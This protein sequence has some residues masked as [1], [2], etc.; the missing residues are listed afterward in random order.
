[1]KTFYAVII[2]MLGML[3]GA[4]GQSPGVVDDPF[5]DLA[6]V[7]V[8]ENKAFL[9]NFQYDYL[10]ENDSLIVASTGTSR[11]DTPTR[12]H[13]IIGQ[14]TPWQNTDEL[15]FFSDV[16]IFDTVGTQKAPN[17]FFGV[18]SFHKE[19]VTGFSASSKGYAGK[20]QLSWEGYPDAG[21][22][23]ILR[24]AQ[25]A[26]LPKHA[27]AK[28]HVK[29]GLITTFSD[30]DVAKDQTYDYYIF[31]YRLSSV[32]NGDD[33]K[34]AGF[35]T[36]VTKTTGSSDNVE[37]RAYQR[38]DV[39][40]FYWKY[41]NSIMETTDFESVNDRVSGNGALIYNR[42]VAIADYNRANA[43][44]Q[45]D[46]VDLSLNPRAVS[47][48]DGVYV[49]VPA[50]SSYAP[51]TL[52]FWLYTGELGH[53][54]VSV[55]HND[56][57][58]LFINIEKD[59]LHYHFGGNSR[60]LHHAFKSNEW[61]YFG[62]S[63]DGSETTIVINGERI[64][65]VPTYLAQPST[66]GVQTIHPQYPVSGNM[67]LGFVRSWNI[68]R[69]VGQ[70]D[71]DKYDVYLR[72][73]VANLKNQW[74]I[75]RNATVIS[76]LTGRGT[77]YIQKAN[78]QGS[79][80][81]PLIVKESYV[82]DRTNIT[83]LFKYRTGESPNTRYNLN[84]Y[85]RGSG[86]SVFS[87]E[88]APD[89]PHGD[90]ANVLE[91]AYLPNEHLGE[92]ALSY[93]TGSTFPTSYQVYRKNEEGMVGLGSVTPN[94]LDASGIYDSAQH[95]DYFSEVNVLAT[96]NASFAL[97]LKIDQ[98]IID[99]DQ[100]LVDLGAMQLI[101]NRD[102]QLEWVVGNDTIFL[103]TIVDPVWKELLFSHRLTTTGKLEISAYLDGASVAK[104]E[105][106]PSSYHLDQFSIHGNKTR[107][108]E[109]GY[110]AFKGDSTSLRQ[111]IEL[112][113]TVPNVVD[114]WQLFYHQHVEEEG[115]AA[116]LFKTSYFK[117]RPF[118]LDDFVDREV[119]RGASSVNSFPDFQLFNDQL[120][121]LLTFTDTF[122]E[123]SS[124]SLQEGAS[125]TYEVRPVYEGTFG[126]Q[127]FHATKNVTI[128]A[129]GL[130]ATFDP[131]Q[132]HTLLNWDMNVLTA[133]GYDSVSVYRNDEFLAHLYK[134]G[135]F[136]DSLMVMGQS[137]IYTL[138]LI[139]NGRVHLVDT[140]IQPIPADGSVAGYLISTNGHFIVPHTN[141]ELTA[142]S[143]A[144]DYDL[145]TNQHGFFAR[146]G[147]S[148]GL[149]STFVREHERNGSIVL[150]KANPEA[151]RTFIELQK[152]DPQRRVSNLIKHEEITYQKV[153]EADFLT[154]DIP[155]EN[156]P[157]DTSYYLNVYV[158]DQ[159]VDVLI[160]T[161]TYSDSVTVGGKNQYSFK[162][163]Y[164]SEDGKVIFDL[165]DYPDS[166]T[167]V[168]NFT[169]TNLSVA[170]SNPY[171]KPM[172][173]WEYPPSKRISRF[174]VYR[175]TP[176]GTKESVTTTSVDMEATSYQ[177]MDD[178]GVPG[179]AY[180]YEVVPFN[181]EEVRDL[182][183]ISASAFTYPDWKVKAP[184]SFS[185]TA[186]SQS[187]LLQCPVDSL[188]YRP[189][190]GFMVKNG[191]KVIGVIPKE[192]YQS[193]DA[194]T[195]TLEYR[196][197]YAFSLV[198]QLQPEVSLY[199]RKAAT[200]VTEYLA[201]SSQHKDYTYAFSGGLTKVWSGLDPDATEKMQA[202]NVSWGK[203]MVSPH[204]YKAYVSYGSNVAGAEP[205]AILDGSA[206]N[207]A[208]D[209][210]KL[211]QNL[212]DHINVTVV[213][214]NESETVSQEVGHIK[215]TFKANAGDN[216]GLPTHFTGSTTS[217]GRIALSWGYPTNAFP[218][219][220]IY[221]DGQRITPAEGLPTYV[222]SYIDEDPSLKPGRYYSYQ[223][224]AVY[225]SPK[226]G[227]S[228]RTPYYNSVGRVKSR[229]HLF[230]QVTD[231]AG[232]PIPY[233]SIQAGNQWV[234]ADSLGYYSIKDA[235]DFAYNQQLTIKAVNAFFGRTE[236]VEVSKTIIP[237][238]NGSYRQDFRFD[239][240]RKR[241]DRNLWLAKAIHPSY[242][243]D[244]FRHELML[245]WAASSHRY[246]YFTVYKWEKEVA[247][248]NA[249]APLTFVDEEV[250]PG[251]TYHY[252][253][254]AV[255]LDE[256]GKEQAEALEDIET[257]LAD[258]PPLDPVRF[259]EATVL[260]DEGRIRF[261]WVH[262]YGNVDGYLIER[263]G[264]PLATIDTLGF[265]DETGVP[266]E[267]YTY[268]VKPYINKMGTSFFSK[269][270]YQLDVEYPGIAIVT[271]F[272]AT[273][274][275]Q[276]YE[277]DLTWEYP[278]N[279]DNILGV[280]I[281]REEDIIAELDQTATSYTDDVGY[282]NTQTVYKI[283]TIGKDP[284][285]DEI[286]YLSKP[287]LDTVWYP[288]IKH[289]DALLL[290]RASK[291]DTLVVA[292]EY[293]GLGIDAFEL[294][295]KD[296]DKNK[297]WPVIE[298]PAEEGKTSY[299][300]NIA[301]QPTGT[302]LE[303]SVQGRRT[304]NDAVYRSEKATKQE[305]FP[306]LPDTQLANQ[307]VNDPY[308]TLTWEYP[309]FNINK[310]RM[311]VDGV[312]TYD[313][314]PGDRNFIYPLKIEDIQA[315]STNS[316][317]T[318]E[319]T[320]DWKVIE[321]I[322]NPGVGQSPNYKITFYERRFK[323]LSG[324]NVT[325]NFELF[326]EIVRG[327]EIILERLD[328]RQLTQRV[329]TDERSFRRV[330]A[331][332]TYCNDA[333]T[334]CAAE[335][336][337][338]VVIGREGDFEISSFSYDYSIG[339]SAADN[340]A[341][342]EVRI[343]WVSPL[344]P[345]LEE[346]KIVRSYFD[347]TGIHSDTLMSLPYLETKE[348]YQV[349]DYIAIEGVTYI[350]EVIGHYSNSPAMMKILPDLGSVRGKAS[351]LAF[352][353]SKEGG[354]PVSGIPFALKGETLGE[355]VYVKDTS[356]EQGNIELVGLPQRTAD[357]ER[358]DY[359]FSSLL[360]SD[361]FDG[362]SSVDFTFGN[363]SQEKV[364][365]P[366]L[367]NRTH[368]ISGRVKYANCSACG[369][370][371]ISVRLESFK[372]VALTIPA[373]A[374]Q[375]PVQTNG[376]GAFSFSVPPKGLFYYKL[377]V[378]WDRNGEYG[379]KHD[380][381]DLETTFASYDFVDGAYQHDFIDSTSF[382]LNVSITDGCAESLG[383]YEFKL[384]VRDT[385]GERYDSVFHTDING[386]L[387]VHVPPYD[388][389]VELIGT[390]QPDATSN[391]IID[392]FRSRKL[393][394]NYEE[395]FQRELKQ[396]ETEG[397]NY[398]AVENTELIFSAFSNLIFLREPF[399]TTHDFDG[400][401]GVG[402]L[403][404]DGDQGEV[405]EVRFSILDNGCA[406]KDG[407]I[408]VKNP[409]ASILYQVSNGFDVN[410]TFEELSGG[411]MEALIFEEEQNRQFV[412]RFT[413]VHPNMVAPYK[414][415]VEVF[416][417][418]N[419]GSIVTRKSFEY[420]V[421][422]TKPIEG[423]DV[424]VNP[425]V[426]GDIDDEV[427]VPL[428]VL[429]DPPGDQS[430]SYL[431]EGTEFTY[432]LNTT[433]AFDFNLSLT[434]TA[435]LET[436]LIA[437]SKTK[438]AIDTRR[439]NVSKQTVG[440]KTKT[441]ISTSATS[442][443]S[444]NLKGN[445]DGRDADV[446]VG[447]GLAYKYG[448]MDRLSWDEATCRP[449]KSETYEVAAD[450]I[451]TTWV[452]TRSMIDQTIKY[453]DSLIHADAKEIDL[454]FNDI[455]QADQERLAELP[456]LDVKAFLQSSRDEWDRIRKHVDFRANPICLMREEF[457]T[458]VGTSDFS[459]SETARNA[460]ARTV[461]NNLKDLTKVAG[462]LQA[463]GYTNHEEI[464]RIQ[465][466]L[467][468]YLQTVSDFL[469]AIEDIDADICSSDL[470]QAVDPLR[471]AGY[472]FTDDLYNQYG[473]AYGD[474]MKVLMTLNY[475]K[476][477]GQMNAIASLGAE[478]QDLDDPTNQAV[479][480]TSILAG[481]FAAKNT[482]SYK[483]AIVQSA[484]AKA[485]IK[486]AEEGD[487][488]ARGIIREA[489]KTVDGLVGMSV[490]DFLRLADRK[491]V[492]KHM[493]KF[494]K[495]SGGLTKIL[496]RL[497]SS[498]TI[499]AVSTFKNG[500]TASLKRLLSTG[501]S[502][503]SAAANKAK[504][505]VKTLFRRINPASIA[506]IGVDVALSFGHIAMAS[507]TYRYARG[508][509]KD[510]LNVLIGWGDNS[511]ETIFG[512]PPVENYTISGG[513]KLE[514]EL[515]YIEGDQTES[516]QHW[517]STLSTDIILG[518]GFEGSL[519]SG[520]PG[521]TD[522]NVG[523]GSFT[524]T[525]NIFDR[526]AQTLGNSEVRKA[527][528]K[529]GYVLHDD[530]E[531]DHITTYVMNNVQIDN[532]NKV[533]PVFHLVG[534]R[535][536]DPY[537]EGTIS[538][539]LPTIRF[540]DEDGNQY[541]TIQTNLDPNITTKIPIQ[542]GS[543]NKFQ[544]GRSLAVT[545]V[546]NSN[547][548]GAEILL[549]NS[550]LF[551]G[552]SNNYFVPEGEDYTYGYVTISPKTG[553]YDYEDLALVI[554]PLGVKDDF[555]SDGAD[556][557]DTLDF[558]LYYR[559][560]VSD[561]RI[562]ER[563]GEWII[564][565]PT[566]NDQNTNHVFF[567][568]G[569]DPEGAFSDL[570]SIEMQ[571]KNVNE[572]ANQWKE[573][574]GSHGS[575]ILSVDTLRTFYQ[576]YIRT[577]VDPTYLF[578]LDLD[579]MPELID[580]RY[581]I[582]ALAHSGNG[583]YSVSN[584]YEGRVDRTIPALVGLPQPS[585]GVFSLGDQISA[586]FDEN[587]DKQHFISH[588]R[589]DVF[590][591]NGQE[592]VL[593]KLNREE[594][595]FNV[596]SS[597]NAI[598]IT[599][600]NSLV[601]AFDGRFATVVLKGIQDLSG[602]GVAEDSVTW[603]FQLDHYRQNPSPVELI[604]SNGWVFNSL[605]NI[606]NEAEDTISFTISGY[607]VYE[608]YSSLRQVVLQVQR[609]GA[610]KWQ[611]VASV[612][613]QDLKDAFDSLGSPNLI[614]EYKMEWA[615]NDSAFMVPDGQYEV[616]ALAYGAQE[617]FSE[618]QTISGTIDRIVPQV[619]G[620]PQPSD[621]ILRDG[622]VVS[623]DFTEAI[624]SENQRIGVEVFTDAASIDTDD[625]EVQ[626][627]S[628]GM[629]VVFDDAFM[630][631]LPPSDTVKVSVTGVE[632]LHGNPA[633]STGVAFKVDYHGV[634]ASSVSI[635][636]NSNWLVNWYSEPELQVVISDY[637][638]AADQLLDSIVLEYRP[639]QSGQEGWNVIETLSKADLV[640]R[641]L[642]KQQP[643]ELP[644][645]TLSWYHYS[646]P[647]GQYE[648][649]AVA[650][651]GQGYTISNYY[652]GRMDR[653]APRIVGAPGPVTKI[654]SFEEVA[655]IS[656]SETINYSE[657]GA[658]V[659]LDSTTITNSDG[660]T[661]GYDDY[662]ITSSGSGIELLIENSY[663]IEHTGDTLSVSIQGIH[664][665]Y[666]NPLFETLDWAFRLEA[667][668][669]RPSAVSLTYPN[670][671]VVNEA[672]KSEKVQFVIE[673]YDLFEY[674]SYLDEVF[675]EY[676]LATSGENAWKVA[677]SLTRARLVSN[678]ERYVQNLGE[679]AIIEPVDT[680]YF[681]PAG[682]SVDGNYEFRARISGKNKYSHSGT[683]SGIIDRQ[684][685]MALAYHPQDGFFSRG[686]ELSV[687]F[688]EA[689]DV[690][691]STPVLNI[692]GHEEK[693][694]FD[695]VLSGSKAVLVPKQPFK[696]DLLSLD[697]HTLSV[698]LKGIHDLV[699]N[700]ASIS[701]KWDVTVNSFRV[702]PSPVTLA[703]PSTFVVTQVTDSVPLTINQFDLSN[704]A[705]GLDVIELEYRL[706]GSDHWI[707]ITSF[708]KDTLTALNQGNSGTLEATYDWIVGDAYAEGAYQ[709]R[710]VSYSGSQYVVSNEVSGTVDRLPPMLTSFEPADG[711][712]S[713]GD[714]IQ[715]DFNE[716]LRTDQR[717]TISYT[718]KATGDPLPNS[719]FTISN[720]SGGVTLLPTQSMVDYDGEEIEVV[721][722][723]I[724]DRVGNQSADV[725]RSFKVDYFNKPPSSVD[726]IGEDGFI[727]NSGHSGE[728]Q[729]LARGY[730]LYEFT[731][732]LDRIALEYR[733][734]SGDNAWYEY[735][736][737]N[738][739]E[740]LTDQQARDVNAEP[741]TSFS[742]KTSGLA[743]GTYELRL[744]AHAGAQYLVSGQTLS[745]VIDKEAPV[746]VFEPQDGFLSR[747]DQLGF[748]SNEAIDVSTT[749]DLK[750]EHVIEGGTN[751]DLT[752]L[753]TNVQ[754]KD[755]VALLVQAYESLEPY[756]G[757]VLQLRLNSSVKDVNGN[758]YEGTMTLPF[759]LDF[760][761]PSI[762]SYDVVSPAG[763]V[764]LNSTSDQVID[765]VIQ[766]YDL[767]GFV[768][769]DRVQLAVQHP[770]RPTT[771]E[772]ADEK[773]GS[774]LNT[775][776]EIVGALNQDVLT[777]V[778]DAHY[779][780]GTYLLQFRSYGVED[781]FNV[782]HTAT[783]IVDRTSP[784]LT[785][786][787]PQDGILSLGDALEYRFNESLST[788]PLATFEVMDED[789]ND[790]SADFTRVQSSGTVTI[791][792]TVDLLDHH[793]KLLTI[794]L[795]DVADVAGNPFR[796]D[797]TRPF[798]VDYFTLPPSPVV[799]K[800]VDNLVI[801]SFSDSKIR[802]L[803]DG[804]DLYEKNYA[805]DSMLLQFKRQTGTGSWVTI[806][807]KD[808]VRLLRE[809]QDKS[810]VPETY[811][812]VDTD[813]LEDGRYEIR[814]MSYGDGQ[815]TYSNSLTGL[816]DR[817]LPRVVTFAPEDEVYNLFDQ[818]EVAFS[819]SIPS[820]DF[821]ENWLTLMNLNGNVP[822]Y[823]TYAGGGSIG[824]N[825]TEDLAT[826]QGDT[827]L[828]ILD[829][830]QVVDEVGNPLEG[831]DTFKFVINVLDVSPSPVRLL[832]SNMV[833]NGANKDQ[834][835]AFLIGGYELYDRN[836]RL[837]RVQLQ[838]QLDGSEQ[839]QDVPGASLTKYELLNNFRRLSD[840]QQAGDNIKPIDTLYW[841]SEHFVEGGFKVRVVVHSGTSFTYSNAVSGL[842][843]RVRPEVIANGFSLVD[844]V[845]RTND[846]I[847]LTF[848]ERIN[849]E[850]F[851]PSWITLE[852][853]TRDEVF[854]IEELEA[855]ATSNSIGVDFSRIGHYRG[856]SL[857]LTIDHVTDFVGNP[858]SGR[859][860]W[861]F[862]VEAGCVLDLQTKDVTIWA[863]DE[864]IHAGVPVVFNTDIDEAY[865]EW[866]FSWG[867]GVENGGGSMKSFERSPLVIFN[868][869]D[870][871]VDVKLT[872]MNE[873][874]CTFTRTEHRAYEVIGNDLTVIDGLDGTS[875]TSKVTV[876]ATTLEMYPNPSAGEEVTIS[877]TSTQTDIVRATIYGMNKAILDEQEFEIT[878]GETDL[879]LDLRKLS[880]EGLFVVVLMADQF[881]RPVKL[882]LQKN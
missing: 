245:S 460:Y 848:N 368:S 159:L 612:P 530:D 370:D 93:L 756:D 91:L 590:I 879:S 619:A 464:D 715:F 372:D 302:L 479:L 225:T 329:I 832:T 392:F 276:G 314:S 73:D 592:E 78:F 107:P 211:T 799:L 818:V 363:P 401:C 637:S 643:G 332:S 840:N 833:V 692:P 261:D 807:K 426:N 682:I 703:G 624:N 870:V 644:I 704:T 513:A 710:A 337:G 10:L 118:G 358:I 652:T 101:A 745:G 635:R 658:G 650:Y 320:Q 393:E 397:A 212:A 772:V 511:F 581:Q 660:T 348:D 770:D 604:T 525:T 96:K 751:N 495:N 273:Q 115:G 53:N 396:K 764:V 87:S 697:G 779:P 309:S 379:T 457:V 822:A 858:L 880:S 179:L 248:I 183:V 467:E 516:H 461:A 458:R 558:Q 231:I 714:A 498:F 2:S 435:K 92:V 758:D 145:S 417:V 551:V 31:A 113:S 66:F 36:A 418:D 75:D 719:L 618:S 240:E 825:F 195:R 502:F 638:F 432:S 187:I 284:N 589:T 494:I 325:K 380:F 14:S 121:S 455:T 258:V 47:Q 442:P 155:M 675:L 295:V 750:V 801:H 257:V 313:L 281:E 794:R 282:P 841:P 684:P 696:D 449:L 847:S 733:K 459:N 293:T 478:I 664:D 103:S 475:I 767:S 202:I 871:K 651:G 39:V 554:R 548:K 414:H 181:T 712:Y 839:W 383:E 25:G 642:E 46:A 377:T 540:A 705:Y 852:N 280:Q 142:T 222:R 773:F 236:T 117:N 265:Y 416:Y 353:R 143:G 213:A 726:L 771:W 536:S 104:K 796:G 242:Y 486:M 727:V 707:A 324:I 28:Y 686:D 7:V 569:Y 542:I 608:K 566:E 252:R 862:M 345:N 716:P 303:V 762:S 153:G 241:E 134:K 192:N 549:A 150:S 795:T 837:D 605:S 453:Y 244:R 520:I 448:I 239:F 798:K 304:I 628:S 786:F 267:S 163:Y 356:D 780:D 826:Y 876:N 808:T 717:V 845:Y 359:T 857:R 819:E 603:S 694:Y 792:P 610:G 173:S 342:N 412:Y 94:R 489:M 512:Y 215:Y 505:V 599:I 672:N 863:S 602:N 861:T 537:E 842:V 167:N 535:S 327:G 683:V 454:G 636:N 287:V 765:F 286:T 33:Q 111:V 809:H 450:G 844:Q 645:D 562:S 761:K 308:Y 766:G 12:K 698:E 300:Y 381:G 271:A 294:H 344:Q 878:E 406:L 60:R 290:D 471:V 297:T 176:D 506:S 441:K 408:I 497:S 164:F 360:P 306:D 421:T 371:S 515:E 119:A 813:D 874:G 23:V 89:S 802:L 346:W 32:D 595:E 578:E 625:Y 541:E 378:D 740:L 600:D 851:N 266:E 781:Q 69:S 480:G 217:T 456:E 162:A 574:I 547:S 793:G 594:G 504:N 354:V 473:R 634:P 519:N 15:Y 42:D 243:Y 731:N 88:D 205:T 656:F 269:V 206:T 695:V 395:V 427:N 674:L 531:G 616:R 617:Q 524:I 158:N 182:S 816:F 718:R 709:V 429:R 485:I 376:K 685:P 50:Q 361:Y 274:S 4:M 759:I 178:E 877:F 649:R 538:R 275:T 582:R 146:S 40:S 373:G 488:V 724:Y 1:M 130:T 288:T 61:T 100:V 476:E 172:I 824:L 503:A 567:L 224:Q 336:W 437:D 738:R 99:Q 462:M 422:G 431:E 859:N 671:V 577:Y 407:Y 673:E 466:N 662:E 856:D 739:D 157:A 873:T 785:S 543:G 338:A 500:M 347:G 292:W 586:S 20:V 580:G 865:Y 13:A 482:F 805:L 131:K 812:E 641:F 854:P 583:A 270:D 623:M 125:Y 27:V 168:S 723:E 663:I 5:Q 490:D 744:V 64:G 315:A 493:T 557:F 702:G 291:I 667:E 797:L 790:L 65:Q 11:I 452:Y 126:D 326:A 177:V 84:I 777:L 255:Y 18:G 746:L 823:T 191:G 665:L 374:P 68:N 355:Y 614:P 299:E 189:F 806:E 875:L 579:R 26:N 533:A 598:E 585:D 307:S 446:I 621:G 423:S 468:G 16:I 409:G 869:G 95:K 687:D 633:D 568:E 216:M 201:T 810:L 553:I 846:A 539:D 620:L 526:V 114:G 404:L 58:N 828:A 693:D 544:E 105:V 677:S 29:S 760:E 434:N 609:S 556:V 783:M 720:H 208:Y 369:I 296:L 653:T 849:Y 180:T 491:L 699:G 626:F 305:R 21:G 116:T 152:N 433:T 154:F 573:L 382:P 318:Q 343:S 123:G 394:L 90:P 606:N 632:D 133:N 340:T 171:W 323:E 22:Y 200:H 310:F 6:S 196:Y 648:L 789:G 59:S 788:N 474:W 587:I 507:E 272:E 782:V 262:D 174:N 670:N 559:K 57:E 514:R 334:N 747:G 678:Y 263:V 784:Q 74:L 49:E 688:N 732:S 588:G 811:F 855:Y 410:K 679:G 814:V 615:L 690:H 109:I 565:N 279:K 362:A 522:P 351:T 470:S 246:T 622:E 834:D 584:V 850:V 218:N 523:D 386:D 106:A 204:H 321:V 481:G 317:S 350:Y 147:L 572:D 521:G 17:Q 398:H 108:F 221:R 753:F 289:V 563:D 283:S 741:E 676:K 259:L 800:S 755:Q 120:I 79:L 127:K 550:E 729:V 331:T 70:L 357:G 440:F 148:Y 484:Q 596:V 736:S 499:G 135:A 44:L 774:D 76:G 413:A 527:N 83:K 232:S 151:T 141:F 390:K 552:R 82:F 138:K 198:D 388:M 728:L 207:F 830:L 853:L 160:N 37:L 264:V 38:E 529:V 301:G 680:L 285:D 238:K 866:E 136:K 140:V 576:N 631:G 71:Q 98:Q 451:N 820:A 629:V 311:V 730:D 415:L 438:W 219:F 713:H 156:T 706:A 487:E 237:T 659:L 102:S 725:T 277:V 748:R 571:Y 233:A 655:S 228:L 185:F 52:E 230:G 768:E 352:V 545:I 555:F 56:R 843:D 400:A 534:G 509:Y 260:K 139:R 721:V 734:T 298:V 197:P 611:T 193:Y 384:R 443:I 528:Y 420:I 836:Y 41:D 872:L 124:E 166:I 868:V 613:A 97:H 708:D 48:M 226:T 640:D 439:T 128:P 30:Y 778:V 24:T 54:Q 821:N 882:V 444:T 3:M 234:Q 465:L 838:R 43:R 247:R 867:G 85:Q 769:L 411:E 591:T 188:D 639:Y 689:I 170:L 791:Q 701:A 752:H 249:G 112:Y 570:E 735:E 763:D 668:P 51:W 700:E 110:A 575:N 319:M 250:A 165:Y 367:Y 214:S 424:F 251:K 63:S 81:Y 122:F 186:T 268:Q 737:K 815:F 316:W 184:V 477:L 803:A 34:R 330:D 399:I 220:H 254:Q 385:S 223:L 501:S 492:E 722:S 256:E 77:L 199:K 517:S 860:S 175:I 804:Y 827:L 691:G 387:L 428:Y 831:P 754:S 72:S 209:A 510:D 402:S 749:I 405:H 817:T 564:N 19:H 711:V 666:G 864:E 561:V 80:P 657:L 62:L 8:D 227:I 194:G 35:V 661:L 787:E 235:T 425:D 546:P 669:E 508:L 646:M 593:R 775:T 743:D 654:L 322:K 169:I 341:S 149:S 445:L 597:D 67:R 391:L 132:Q 607:D 742:F 45:F 430:Y 601:S 630:K 647:D 560:P 137:H 190:D 681:D 9:I 335:S 333:Y 403:V 496:A 253:I 144:F 532:A 776:P 161:N 436:F 829:T 210:T 627:T 86:T 447:A 483:A 229:I 472:T 518:V 203:P 757:Q 463:F 129:L 469:V 835:R 389:N 339:V 375:T 328:S 312:Y 364:F 55:L 366:F 349:F 881:D 365:N 278:E 419:T